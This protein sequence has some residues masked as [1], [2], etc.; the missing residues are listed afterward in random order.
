MKAVARLEPGSIK[1]D[2]FQ[3]ATPQISV[4]PESENSLVRPAELARACE[5]PAAVDPD[6]KIER[7]AV[8]KRDTFGSKLGTSVK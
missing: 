8:F 2:V 5:N 1:A 4:D 6:R 7:I 3:R